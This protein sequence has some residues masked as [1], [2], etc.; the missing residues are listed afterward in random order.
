MA[1]M[2]TGSVELFSEYDEEMNSEDGYSS[3]SDDEEHEPTDPTH[4]RFTMG[5]ENCSLHISAT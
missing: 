4:T 1:E 2:D 3:E 5:R